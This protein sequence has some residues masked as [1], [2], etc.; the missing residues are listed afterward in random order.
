MQH[1]LVGYKF[2][3]FSEELAAFIR[4]GPDAIGTSYTSTHIDYTMSCPIK[5]TMLNLVIF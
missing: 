1:R 4:V 3:D 5:A 2:T